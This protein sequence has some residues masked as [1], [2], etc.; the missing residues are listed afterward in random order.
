M[1][2]KNTTRS[3]TCAYPAARDYAALQKDRNEERKER[4]RKKKGKEKKGKEKKRVTSLPGPCGSV[5]G[6]TVRRA[7]AGGGQRGEEERKR[8]LQAPSRTASAVLTGRGTPPSCGPEPNPESVHTGGVFVT[9]PPRVD[10]LVATLAKTA[11]GAGRRG[12]SKRRRRR[13]RRP[14]PRQRRGRGSEAPR[15]AGGHR[16]RRRGGALSGTP[17]GASVPPNCTGKGAGGFRHACDLYEV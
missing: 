5:L 9:A 2:A 14:Q 10:E 1:C 8:P 17:P 6:G 11:G 13:G 16:T 15:R 12:E 4:K 7:G 3:A